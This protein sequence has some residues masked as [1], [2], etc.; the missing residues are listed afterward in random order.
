[1]A[2]RERAREAERRYRAAHLERKRASE[3]ASK[4][5]ARA[6]DPEAARAYARE[7][8][9]KN[10]DRI[11]A[12]SKARYDAHAERERQH[13]RNYR[14]KNRE[15]TNAVVRQWRKEHPDKAKACG[16]KW[17][18]DNPA[19]VKA[20]RRRR[21]ALLNGASV[22]DLTAKQWATIQAAFDHRC[23]YCGKRRKGHL[24][25]DHITPLSKC[26]GHTLT[27]VVPACGPCNSTKHTGR[28]LAP[29]QPLLLA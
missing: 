1:M 29:V 6:N 27:N 16:Q 3:S 15:K 28:P 26:G 24:T 8:Y 11:R 7:F 18:R 19:A 5:R 20:C 21:R 22:N 14:A 13:S 10:K 2:D 25:Q 4:R 17:N 12:Q 9:A 23:A